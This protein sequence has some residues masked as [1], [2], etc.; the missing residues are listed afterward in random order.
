MILEG[1][2]CSFRGI[3][4]V[5]A[6]GYQLEVDV[7]VPHVLFEEAGGFVVQFLEDRFEAAG[8]EELMDFGVGLSLIH[9]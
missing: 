3:A 9:I 4:S 1:G 6:G 2:D 5:V 8:D 7:V